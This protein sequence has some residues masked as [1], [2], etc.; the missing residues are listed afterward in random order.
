MSLSIVVHGQHSCDTPFHYK[1]KHS[2]SLPTVPRKRGVKTETT[3]HRNEMKTEV[4]SEDLDSHMQNKLVA[5][6]CTSVTSNM[7]HSAC[8]TLNYHTHVSI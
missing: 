5:V 2:L 1:E 3:I 4:I 7:F 8:F 6:E